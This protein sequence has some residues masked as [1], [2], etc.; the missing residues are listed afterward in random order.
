[1]LSKREFLEQWNKSVAEGQDDKSWSDAIGKQ[2]TGAPALFAFADM[3]YFALTGQIQWTPDAYRTGAVTVPHGF[4]TDFASVPRLFWSMLP[5]M[6]RYGYA[7][8]FHDFAYWEQNVSRAE[9]DALFR[10]TM[11][12]LQVSTWTRHLLYYS[13]R[14][15][16]F[17]AWRSNAALKHSGEKRQLRMLPT[18]IKTRWVDWKSRPGVFF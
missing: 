6:G 2:F 16:G 14:W 5:P 1:M 9:A 10:D 3:D 18:D 13:V 12:E 4:V 7:A 11:I 17:P 15:F 8:V